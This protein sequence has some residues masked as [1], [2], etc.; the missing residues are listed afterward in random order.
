MVWPLYLPFLRG[1]L[2][3]FFPKTKCLAM[4]FTGEVI[5]YRGIVLYL[6]IIVI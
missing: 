1:F 4:Q 2:F 5:H 6:T 3:F